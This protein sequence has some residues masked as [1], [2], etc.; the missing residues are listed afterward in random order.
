MAMAIS[1]TEVHTI[2]LDQSGQE[3]RDLTGNPTQKET[4]DEGDFNNKIANAMILPGLCAFLIS[5]AAFVSSVYVFRQNQVVDWNKERDNLYLSAVIGYLTAALW[6]IV[7]LLALAR[8]SVG[9][10]G[11]EDYATTLGFISILCGILSALGVLSKAYKLVTDHDN[12][13]DGEA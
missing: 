13:R 9:P 1:A 10:N 4:F 5:I 12:P 2:Y 11:A 6:S 7:G 8:F 3:A